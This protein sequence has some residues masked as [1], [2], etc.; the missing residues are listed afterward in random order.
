MHAR[1]RGGRLYRWS[2]RRTGECDEESCLSS[3]FSLLKSLVLLLSLSL[4][5]HTHNVTTHTYIRLFPLNLPPPSSSLSDEAFSRRV[6]KERVA[7]R[8]VKL[9]CCKRT[10]SCTNMMSVVCLPLILVSALSS[11]G[12]GVGISQDVL[13]EGK[14]Y[15]SLHRK[16]LGPTVICVLTIHHSFAPPFLFL[17][18]T[19]CLHHRRRYLRFHARHRSLS[20][21]NFTSRRMS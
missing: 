7:A 5:A 20:E 19:K 8:S 11:V 12:T 13:Y 6:Q 9:Q 3:T 4:S 14:T 15:E 10:R 2:T 17:S 18:T 16:P 1:S 21:M